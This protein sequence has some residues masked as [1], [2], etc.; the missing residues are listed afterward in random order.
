MQR[1]KVV[2]VLFENAKV[3]QLFVG[4]AALAVR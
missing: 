1:V 2:E 3:C 4:K